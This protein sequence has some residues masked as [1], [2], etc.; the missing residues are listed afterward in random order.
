MGW[1]RP[2]PREQRFSNLHKALQDTIERSNLVTITL[3][4]AVVGSSYDL[5]V[6]EEAIDPCLTVEQQHEAH[7]GLSVWGYNKEG[8]RWSL[9]L[10]KEGKTYVFQGGWKDMMR[11]NGWDVEGAKIRIWGFLRDEN[12]GNAKVP[13]FVFTFHD[14]QH[15]NVAMS[16]CFS[17]CVC[18]CVRET[19]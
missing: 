11:Q 8:M 17:E 1:G 18:V 16:K 2:F 7:G 3:E 13:Q 19:E 12:I 5:S 4:D 10:R 6:N 14:M 9:R 15:K